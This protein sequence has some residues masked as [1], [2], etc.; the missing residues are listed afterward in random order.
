[1]SN[2][3][4]AEDT[5][6]KNTTKSGSLEEKYKFMRGGLRMLHSTVYLQQFVKKL[7]R[8]SIF[9]FMYMDTNSCFSLIAI[10]E[11]VMKFPAVI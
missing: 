4:L 5:F 1:M 8:I 6:L 11:T 9:F 7:T 2:Q 10:F 3:K